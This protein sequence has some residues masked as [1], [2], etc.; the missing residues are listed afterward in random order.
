MR[1]FELFVLRAKKFVG[2]EQNIELG[3]KCASDSLFDAELTSKCHVQDAVRSDLVIATVNGTAQARH[4]SVC[5]LD[6]EPA[7]VDLETEISD[8]SRL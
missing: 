2:R 4:N 3:S 7:R 1:V 8:S 6:D 5:P